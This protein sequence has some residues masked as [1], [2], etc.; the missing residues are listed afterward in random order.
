[1]PATSTASVVVLDDRGV[2]LDDVVAVARH[3]ARVEFTERSL[4]GMAV[5]RARIDE[6]AGAAEPKYG[7]STGFGALATRHISPDLRTQLQR[8]LIRS[9]AAGM[10]DPVEREVV[11]ALMFLRLKTLASGRTGIRPEP[12]STTTS[13]R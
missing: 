2:T 11:R 10:G 3:D 12:S 6:L 7:I 8:S 5:T 13:P 9:H 1:M 4:E